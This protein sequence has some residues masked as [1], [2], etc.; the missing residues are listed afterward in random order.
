MPIEVEA[1]RQRRDSCTVQLGGGAS[2]VFEY[3]PVQVQ[4]VMESADDGTLEQDA[5]GGTLSDARLLVAT[6]LVEMVADW[7]VTRGGEPFP[8]DADEIAATFDAGSLNRC[9]TGIMEHYATGK[10]D[11]ELLSR[12]GTAITS[13]KV[14]AESSPAGMTAASRASRQSA[15]SQKSHSKAG[16]PRGRL[17]RIPNGTTSSVP[18]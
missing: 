16:S 8:L 2:I 1:I 5:A 17:R 12:L 18:A 4:E 13:R 15:N 7:D 9:V 14:G 11:G 6:R 3:L 10:S